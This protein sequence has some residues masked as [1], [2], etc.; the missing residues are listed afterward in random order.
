MNSRSIVLGLATFACAMLVVVLVRRSTGDA[1]SST[2]D[3]APAPSVR[4]ADETSVSELS[5]SET[6]TALP[7]TANVDRVRT[8]ARETEDPR[9]RR[10]RLRARMLELAAA[11]HWNELYGSLTREQA[12]AR[13]KEIAG[14]VVEASSKEFERLWNEGDFVVI[15]E[16]TTYDGEALDPLDVYQ[17]RTS[18]G[19]EVQKCT[20]PE[21]FTKLY[22][23]RALAEWLRETPADRTRREL[24]D[25]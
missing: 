24:L 7:A 15:A 4:S 1:S 21:G 10:L 23:L 12:A 2:T 14:R 13:A 16:G 8:T 5:T 11:E 3:L 9:A 20:L 19:G 18:P 17:V 25:H 6:T 22:R